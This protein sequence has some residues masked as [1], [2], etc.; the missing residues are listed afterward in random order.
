M[1]YNAVEASVLPGRFLDS[2]TCEKP[3]IQSG[4]IP[5]MKIPSMI[6][7]LSLAAI[8]LWLAAA[9]PIR[10]D[11]IHRYSFNGDAKDSIGHADGVLKG[12]GG[13]FDGAGQLVLPGGG[14]S[15]DAADTIAG[16]VDLPN[17]IINVLTNLTLQAWVTWNGSGS[18]QRILDFGTSAGGEEV[19]NGNGNYLFLSPQG[20][21]NL[22]F[23]V[24]DPATGTEPVQL[25]AGAPLETGREICVTVT[26]DYTANAARLYSNNVLLVSGPASVP[27][28]TINDVNNWLGRS[29]WN[30][31]MFAGSYNEF[32]IYDNALN[33]LEV[34]ASYSSG[35]A[36]P[37]TDIAALGTL[38]NVHLNVQKTTLTE[39][40][41][42]TSTVT[43]DYATLSNLR[44]AGVPGVTYQS[45]NTN[46]VSISATG[47]ITAVGAGT[48]NVSVSFGGKTGT[49]AITVNRR[50]QGLAVAGTLYVDLRA[51]DVKTST[52]TWPNKAGKG[53]FNAVGTPT[54][55]ADV[56]G[57]GVAGV[58]F[59][60]TVDGQADAY[61][62]P[63][64]TSDLDQNSDRSIEVW[65]FNPEIAPE[66]TLVAWGH[67]G[68][69]NDSNMSFNYG[70][71]GSYGAVGHWGEDI[72]W[73]GTPTAGQWHYLVYTYDGAGLAKVY[74]DG[75]LKSQ[76]TYAAG[77]ITW[78]DLAIRIGAQANGSGDDF[79]YGQS[80]SGS[81]AAI[82]VHGG[83]LTDNDVK[84]NFLLGIEGTDPGALAGISFTL[85]SPTLI[86][87][88]AQSTSTVTADYPTRKYLQVGALS[89]FSSSDT[90]I[91]TVDA[92]GRVTGVAVGTASIT[93]SYQGK[94]AS[95]SVTVM[96]SPPP[97]LVHR[98]SFSEAAGSTTVKDSVGT[99][100]G[101]LMGDLALGGGFSNGKLS[102][103]GGGAS[104]GAPYVDLPNKIIST[105]TNASFE[106]WVTWQGAGPGGDTW[107]RVFDFGDNSNGED[108]QGTGQTYLFLT[109]L[110]GS[111]V[112]RF[113]ASIASNGAEDPVLNAAAPL[114]IGAPTYLAVSYDARGQSSR[115]YVNGK[116]EASGG[117]PSALKQ[118]ND[119]NVWLGR[120]NWGDP[121][122]NG[123]FDEFRIWEGALTDEEVAASFAAGPNALPSTET[124]PSLG[125]S[126]AAKNL[127]ITWPVSATGFALESSPAL[128]AQAQW[129]AVTANPVVEGSQNKVTVPITGTTT[130]YRLHK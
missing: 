16:Y 10:A 104:S 97:V 46:I 1:K 105:M 14:A 102:L 94:Q 103:P 31:A 44:V 91:A 117:A 85:A 114:T 89:T 64:S 99:A 9:V 100:D 4:L 55:S 43:A 59:K 129:T 80:F 41:Q 65:V 122:F 38:Q 75:Q 98:Y 70:S 60:G 106:A 67:R 69:P 84:N 68:G 5:I 95:Q 81:I 79:D 109:P 92:T 72:G 22:R 87:L 28:S 53:D 71:N 62:G 93:A 118:F 32:R 66:E 83:Q 12:N 40:D 130:F 56:G 121:Y 124:K 96:L 88:G 3:S 78:A 115:L 26:Y 7:T 18:W 49:S 50:Q 116:R 112:V 128:G 113:G 101:T 86:G 58:T 33:S 39:A 77:L 19:V 13:A 74:S 82:R 42:T 11:L 54:Y 120:S 34:A 48:A 107:Q 76:R 61:V 52:A 37:S 63:N 123:D 119:I 45:D 108:A 25:T 20:D 126:L 111:T 8:A 35:V 90:N 24:R 6:R 57:T 51:S 15:A 29:Q 17:H 2:D 125:V 30:D 23:A 110:G 47:G 73:N 27:L 21:V 36:T 127:S